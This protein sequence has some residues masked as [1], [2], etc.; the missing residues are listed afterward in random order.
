MPCTHR[1]MTLTLL[2]L[3]AFLAACP[4]DPPPTDD[5]DDDSTTPAPPERLL[6]AFPV[7][8]PWLINLVVGVDHDPVETDDSGLGIDC[9]N[10]DGVGFPFCYDGHDG[11]DFILQGAFSQMDDGSAQVIAAAPGTV[12]SIE[13]DQYDRCH[14]S[15][16]AVTCDGHPIIGNHVIIEHA[17]GV[18]TKYWHLMTDSVQVEV[19]E[20][21]ECG[22]FLALIGSSGNSSMPHLHFEVDLGEEGP[23]IDPYAGPES[24][25]ESWWTEQDGPFDVPGSDCQ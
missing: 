25:P 22:D 4:S 20:T 8:E 7:A 3:V 19:G 15:G 1:A 17:D 23:V 13:E 24:Q 14:I 5:D 10:Y 21:V 16:T 11:S 18:R 6:F 9:T 12:V 2:T